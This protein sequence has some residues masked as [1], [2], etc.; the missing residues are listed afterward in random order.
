[1]RFTEPIDPRTITVRFAA[2]VQPLPTRVEV[3]TDWAS[4]TVSVRPAAV[5][6]Q[7]AVPEGKT[8]MLRLTVREVDGGGPGVGVA[9]ADLEIPGVE[10]ERTLVVPDIGAPALLRF[11]V[12]PGF[13]SDC[14]AVPNGVVC[15]QTWARHSEESA[16]LDRTFTLTAPR[17]YEASAMVRLLPGEML[18]NLLDTGGAG[19][20]QARHPSTAP[21]RES[22]PGAA[23]DGDAATAWVADI[24]DPTPRLSLDLGS[25]RL[26]RA[27]RIVV[28]DDAPVARPTVVWVQAGEETWVGALPPDGLIRLPWPASTDSIEITIAESERR[29]TIFMRDRSVRRLPAGISE[30]RLDPSIPAGEITAAIDVG[31]DAGLALVADGVSIPLAVSADRSDVLAG[32]PV[33][34]MPCGDASVPLD[35]GEHRFTLSATNW[36]APIALTLA[37]VDLSAVTPSP[38]DVGIENWGTTSRQRPR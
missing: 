19:R 18:D 21:T 27:V 33:L 26:V 20:A 24:G 12:A 34:A 7:L 37:D 13:R 14:L 29:Q 11:A 8:S 5:V 32:F 10:P 6:Q 3:T 1:M 31:C 25:E 15:D 30:V 35:A 36:A 22:A 17:S 16:A 2:D 28:N 23:I 9:I 38:R 4:S